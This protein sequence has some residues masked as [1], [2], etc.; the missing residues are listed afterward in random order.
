[1]H[2][3]CE[4]RDQALSGSMHGLLHMHQSFCLTPQPQAMM[5]RIGR[6]ISS[7]FVH[8]DL[9]AATLLS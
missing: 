1:M 9:V 2:D 6:R 8:V 5:G 4:S 7:G 3:L